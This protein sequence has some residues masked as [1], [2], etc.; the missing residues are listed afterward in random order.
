MT[1][2]QCT[3]RKEEIIAE[4]ENRLGKTIRDHFGSEVLEPVYEAIRSLTPEE[5]EQWLNVDERFQS[6]LKDAVWTHKDPITQEGQSIAYLHR[7]WIT[8]LGKLPYDPRGHRELM[9]FAVSEGRINSRHEKAAPGCTL[10]LRD[11][12]RA[13]IKGIWGMWETGKL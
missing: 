2:Q 5:L 13:Y 11:A 7:R 8:I 3:Q 10:F 6:Q 9:E 1:Q 4:W 12:I